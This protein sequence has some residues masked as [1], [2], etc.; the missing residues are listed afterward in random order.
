[1]PY[2]AQRDPYAFTSGSLISVA[3]NWYLLTNAMIGAQE[4]PLYGRAMRVRNMTGAPLVLVVVPI[5]EPD[6]AA[7]QT[8]TVDQTEMLPFAVRRIVSI[9]GG[10]TIPAL[11]G[12]QVVT[13]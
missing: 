10:T 7:T 1:M 9:N 4:L 12:V 3:R 2:D 6:D 8:I 13:S 5:S 11:T